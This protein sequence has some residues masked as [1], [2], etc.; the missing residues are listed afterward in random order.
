MHFK[1]N[2]CSTITFVFLC[3]GCV[4]RFGIFLFD[5]KWCHN[6]QNT[7]LSS[8]HKRVSNQPKRE[9]IQSMVNTKEDSPK[10]LK[11]DMKNSLNSIQDFENALRPNHVQNQD[12]AYNGA[13]LKIDR[14][15]KPYNLFKQKGKGGTGYWSQS[16]QDRIVDELLQGRAGLFFIESGGYDGEEHS[17]SLFFEVNRKWQGMVIEPNPH[18]YAKILQKNRRCMTVNAAISPSGKEDFLPFILAGPL[19]GFESTFSKGHRKRLESEI[20]RGEKWMHGKQGSGDKVLVP[21]FPLKKFLGAANQSIFVIDYWSL[22]TEGS[23]PLILK[24]TDFS[25]IMVGVLSVEHNSDP[26][27]QN[28]IMHVMTAAGFRMYLDMGFDYIFFNPM[29]FKSH[30][31]KL[32]V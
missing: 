3:L 16:G 28:E 31:L 23:E 30:G 4:L 13:L 26:V 9:N 12:E 11:N 2:K 22:D 10:N 25:T 7:V 32:P 15:L 5:Q 27:K 21:C 29:Y 17:N 20:A 24:A 14:V 18:L 8:G 6:T 1:H 19:G